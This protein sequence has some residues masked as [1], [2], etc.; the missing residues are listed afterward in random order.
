[1]V[2]VGELEHEKRVERRQKEHDGAERIGPGR[3]DAGTGRG[4]RGRTGH[5][6]QSRPARK[7]TPVTFVTFFQCTDARTVMTLRHYLGAWD[8]EKLES[9]PRHRCAAASDSSSA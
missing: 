3:V 8:P 7:A 2:T 4:K 1:R 9:S 6:T 5:F